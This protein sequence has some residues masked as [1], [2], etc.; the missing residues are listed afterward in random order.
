MATKF[1]GV[2]TSGK[3]FRKQTPKSPPKS[4]LF[5]YLLTTMTLV[6]NN[7]NKHKIVNYKYHH[8]ADVVFLYNWLRFR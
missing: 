2:P 5:V 6:N 3:R 7:Y 8:C 4:S 1:G